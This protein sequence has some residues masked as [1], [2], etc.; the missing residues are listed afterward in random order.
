[1]KYVLAYKAVMD[2]FYVD[3]GA[4]T[5]EEAVKLHEELQEMFG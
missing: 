1:M 4:D 3:T 2:S 5:P